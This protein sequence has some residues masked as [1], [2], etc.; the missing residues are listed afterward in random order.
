MKNIVEI[1]LYKLRGNVVRKIKFFNK[2]TNND[3]NNNKKC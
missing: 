1:L 2:E 3:L